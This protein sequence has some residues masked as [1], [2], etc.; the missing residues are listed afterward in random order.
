MSKSL[1]NGI[2]LSDDEKTVKTKI[3]SMYTDPSHINITDPGHVEGNTV[4]TY[5]DAFSKQEDFA[6]FLPE[7]ANLEEM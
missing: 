2:Y 1:G 4:F 7:Y 3:M 5:L 6:E